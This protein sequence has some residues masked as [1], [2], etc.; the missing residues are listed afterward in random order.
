MKASLEPK[1]EEWMAWKFMLLLLAT[2]DEHQEMRK[3][4]GN[5]K[6][7]EANSGMGESFF[8]VPRDERK[9]KYEILFGL[10][11]QQT[12]YWNKQFLAAKLLRQSTRQAL[13]SPA[14]NLSA[15]GCLIFVCRSCIY[16]Y[17]YS[18]PTSRVGAI[19]LSISCTIIFG[20][21]R[22]VRKLASTQ[23]KVGIATKID[24]PLPK[25]GK[26]QSGKI[27]EAIWREFPD[28]SD[29]WL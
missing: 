12:N 21:K 13:L 20:L 6:A 11:F 27:I 29:C 22:F 1:R 3:H 17:V 15:I 24:A 7:H 10:L 25:R 18:Q 9:A 2:L 19:K 28:K 14:L 5:S 4:D 8:Q 26:M 23:H 16:I